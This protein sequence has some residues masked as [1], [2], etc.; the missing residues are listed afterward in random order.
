LPHQPTY[1]LKMHHFHSILSSVLGSSIWFVSLRFSH[2]N[3]VYTSPLTHTC[4]MPHLSLSSWFD[5]LKNI[6]LA[7]QIIKLLNMWFSPL[8]LL[9]LLGPNI[10]LN[11][12]ILLLLLI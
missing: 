12:H 9:S 8:S 11:T 1:G 5:H 2:E 10:F 4:Y 7:V 3:P 6:W